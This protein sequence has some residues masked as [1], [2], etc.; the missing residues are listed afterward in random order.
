MSARPVEYDSWS[1]TT[2]TLAALLDA[3]RATSCTRRRSGPARR[4]SGRRGRS[5][6]CCARS[7]ARRWS[8]SRRRTRGPPSS[9]SEPTAV[10]SSLP[11]GPITPTMLEFDANDC[12]TVEA[13]AGLSCVSPWTMLILSLWLLFHWAAKNSA[14]W[15]WSS[16]IEATGPVNGPIIPIWIGFA[17]ET[18]GGSR[19]LPTS[20]RA[21]DARR[22]RARVTRTRLRATIE[23]CLSYHQA[24]FERLLAETRQL[25]RVEATS[26]L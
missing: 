5:S 20:G 3:E 24:S 21:R 4:R 7:S 18:A 12:A 25:P 22:R 16:P 26:L 13:I 6:P 10:T 2:I 9:G 19:G 1:S 14:Q 23:C 15:S 17:H 8:P 11:A